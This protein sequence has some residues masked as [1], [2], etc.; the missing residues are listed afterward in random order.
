MSSM[1]FARNSAERTEYGKINAMSKKKPV[2][3]N[4]LEEYFFFSERVRE[5]FRKEGVKVTPATE[6]WFQKQFRSG[7]RDPKRVVSFYL[8]NPA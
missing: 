4:D 1:S 3:Y 6:R 5:L 7:K 2:M 8:L